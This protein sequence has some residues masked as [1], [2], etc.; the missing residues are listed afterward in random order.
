MARFQFVRVCVA[1]LC[2]MSIP[3]LAGCGSG[4][5]SASSAPPAKSEKLAHESELLTLTLRPETEKRLGI[6]TTTLSSREVVGTIVAQGEIVAPGA[7]G[8]V[9]LTSST[10]L[11]ALATNQVRADGDVARAAAELAQAEKQA[12]RANALVR[13]QAESEKTRE[14]ALTTLAVARANL[15]TAR[16]AREILGTGVSSMAQGSTLWVRAALFGGDL[17]AVDKG[18]PVEVRGIGDTSGS[19]IARPVRGPPSANGTTGTIDLYYVLPRLEAGF[20][21]GQRVSV[22]IPSST[23]S[24][25]LAVPAA[26][27]LSDIYGGEWV[28]VLTKP[29]VYER[30]RIEVARMSQGNALVTRGLD[31]GA[32]VV[33]AGAAELFGTEFGA[34]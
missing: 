34:K 8:I 33:T 32:K 23:R 2:A 22:A 13:E 10:D 3:M 12:A 30:R 20:R 9:V 19:L 26:A 27:I 15:R 14:E 11:A 29:H 16:A 5:D 31:A 18:A 28:Y 17:D 24:R 1:I 6:Q 4:K 7:G 21:I 25:G